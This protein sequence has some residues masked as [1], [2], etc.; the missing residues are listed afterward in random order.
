MT[1]VVFD[2]PCLKQ[3]KE[4]ATNALRCCPAKIQSALSDTQIIIENFAPIE[5]LNEL[6]VKNKNELLGLY[7]MH[8][9]SNVKNLILYR[10][11][12]VL[13]ARTSNEAISNVVARV[14][15][16]EISHRANCI[17]LRK[18]WLDKIRRL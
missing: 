13:Y 3:I 5:V 17:S 14:T 1:N 11:P 7:K 12:L 16:Y 18:Q 4:Y 15:V 6:R 8:N 2:V 9:D 10:G